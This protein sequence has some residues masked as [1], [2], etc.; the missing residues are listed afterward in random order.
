MTYQQ[1]PLSA[2]FPPMG[3]DEFQSLKDSIE[4][5]GVQNAI[6]LYEGMVLDGWHRYCAAQDL[7]MPCPE[8]ELAADVDPFDFVKAQNKERRHLS[9]GAW[10]LIEAELWDWFSRGRP[11]VNKAGIVTAPFPQFADP[12][13]N[14]APGADLS[15]GADEETEKRAPGAHLSDGVEKARKT[16]A[17]IAQGG[18]YS[19][20][21]VK[22]AKKVLRDAIPEI[23]N[24]TKKDEISLKDAEA[25][26]NLSK[27]KQVALAAAGPAAIKKAAKAQ[28]RAKPKGVKE[29]R[30]QDL[31]EAMGLPQSHFCWASRTLLSAIEDLGEGGPDEDEY[32]YLRQIADRCRSLVEDDADD[33]LEALR[34]E[35]ER[36]ERENAELRAAVDPGAVDQLRTLQEKLRAVEVIRDDLM[37]AN[38]RL[39]EENIKLKRMN[40]G[41]KARG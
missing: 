22:Q 8:V 12:S 39:N 33:Q 3:A 38:S 29:A 20:R 35:V 10:A 34:S 24:S 40:K 37:Q 18:G 26:S 28:K 13:D 41:G 30:R 9:V 5:I 23:Q 19:T 17:E 21:T 27:E 32:A 4:N 2:A 16:A 6:T 31:E 15:D 11:T 1:H 7:G 14:P 36:L 25:I